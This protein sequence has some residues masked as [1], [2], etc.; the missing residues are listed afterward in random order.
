MD[1]EQK[2]STIEEN[3][4]SL[5]DSSFSSEDIGAIPIGSTPPNETVEQP[6]RSRFVLSAPVVDS[7]GNLIRAKTEEDVESKHIDQELQELPDDADNDDIPDEEDSMAA[8]ELEAQFEMADDILNESS[9]DPGPGPVIDIQ[10]NGEEMPEESK[11]WTELDTHT[12]IENSLQRIVKEHDSEMQDV[13]KNLEEQRRTNFA[14]MRKIESLEKRKSESKQRKASDEKKATGVKPL[15]FAIFIIQYPC[16]IVAVVLILA[17]IAGW[18]DAMV[19]ELNDAGGLEYLITD[20]EDTGRLYAYWG[21]VINAQEEVGNAPVKTQVDTH[22]QITTLFKTRDGSDILQPQYLPFIKE[23]H[24]KIVNWDYDEYYRLCLSDT[25]SF[26]N[27]SSEAVTD[28]LIDGLIGSKSIA[29]VSQQDIDDLVSSTISTSPEMAARFYL[30]FESSF[31]NSTDGGSEY[32]RAFF[33]EYKQYIYIQQVQS[34]SLDIFISLSLSHNIDCTLLCFHRNSDYHI[35]TSMSRRPHTRT[36][37]SDKRSSGNISKSGSF[38]FGR[39][40][41]WRTTMIPIWRW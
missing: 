18:Y 34:M 20:A 29:D 3:S 10:E 40:F 24:A 32:Y 26:P 2:L 22:L 17:V 23:V 14:L 9:P 27:C 28:P 36:R 8:Q 30:H 33:V 15:S 7:S 37:L 35:R 19:F 1:M 41:S 31:A 38:R 25:A 4:D 21:A 11:Q 13:R 16:V 12:E 6:K 39:T 5:L